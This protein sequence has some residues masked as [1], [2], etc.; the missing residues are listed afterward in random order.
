MIFASKVA[1]D[2]A[3]TCTRGAYQRGL[4]AG[5]R[6]WNRRDLSRIENRYW[7]TRAR[8]QEGLRAR[9]EEKA[10]LH[11]AEVWTGEERELVVA[12]TRR[13][14]AGYICRNGWRIID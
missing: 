1:K 9:M 10:D 12:C 14:L 4:V 13:G 8:S 5:R 6:Q 3:M 2:R 7:W 11:T